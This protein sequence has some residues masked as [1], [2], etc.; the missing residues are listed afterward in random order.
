LQSDTLKSQDTKRNRHHLEI[1]NDSSGVLGK[2]KGY[3]FG[4]KEKQP[5]PKIITK[6]KFGK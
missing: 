1:E 3:F 5:A 6:N 4:E 2:L